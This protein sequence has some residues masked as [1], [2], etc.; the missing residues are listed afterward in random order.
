MT[1][2]DVEADP[3]AA[4][5]QALPPRVRDQLHHTAR[6]T[7][8]AYRA[9]NTHGWTPEQLA[10]ECTRDTVHVINAAAVLMHRLE[11]CADHPP[12]KD[13][14]PRRVPFC[15]PECR[16]NGGMILDPETRLPLRK[17]ECRTRPPEGAA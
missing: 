11:W 4:F 17:C 14:T 12:A 3:V 5:R 10:A 9:V 2:A 13:S 16:D 6:V 8:L 15:S 1:T 7:V